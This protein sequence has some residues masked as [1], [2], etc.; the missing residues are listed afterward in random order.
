[1]TRINHF[2]SGGWS[3]DETLTSWPGP[4]ETCPCTGDREVNRSS[5]SEVDPMTP[6]REIFH[7]ADSY[8]SVFSLTLSFHCVLVC[9][10]LTFIARNEFLIFVLFLVKISKISQID[11]ITSK[12]KLHKKS[13]VF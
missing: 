12:A 3:P 9:L 2:S 8:R 11:T 7:A 5:L 10:R 6:L 13:I 1:M 4:K